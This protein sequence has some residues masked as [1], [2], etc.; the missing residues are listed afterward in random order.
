MQRDAFERKEPFSLRLTGRGD[1]YGEVPSAGGPV[2]DAH[3][4]PQWFSLLTSTKG[5]AHESGDTFSPVNC[6][7]IRGIKLK[8]MHKK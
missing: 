6:K 3:H 1:L 2:H 7:R 5:E 8:N 4:G